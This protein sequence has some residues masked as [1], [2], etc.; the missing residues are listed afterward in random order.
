MAVKIRLKRIG[1]NP[2]KN[3]HFRLAAFNE[4]K[5]RDSRCLEELGFYNPLSG[6]SKL[7]KDR[8]NYWLKNGAIASKTVSDLIKKAEKGS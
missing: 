5:G 3:P 6:E 2:K 7:K 1:K 8:I 4:T